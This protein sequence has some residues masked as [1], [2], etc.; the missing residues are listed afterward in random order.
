[1]RRGRHDPQRRAQRQQQAYEE[2]ER[3][4][5]QL[6]LAEGAAPKQGTHLWLVYDALDRYRELYFSEELVTLK[7][8]K[9]K[10][11]DGMWL[12]ATPEQLRRGLVLVERCGRNTT[13]YELAKAAMRICEL[14]HGKPRLLLAVI[15]RI[16]KANP[17][18]GPVRIPP[19][20]P[21]R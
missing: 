8:R 20:Y 5:V 10:I 2:L 21:A 11:L 15:D 13:E 16:A 14:T 3:R 9:V 4:T 18:Q 1:M 6:A 19:Q 12:A 17:L 7:I